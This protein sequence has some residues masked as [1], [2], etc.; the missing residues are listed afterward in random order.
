M[1]RRVGVCPCVSEGGWCHSG[2]GNNSNINDVKESLLVSL[3]CTCSRIKEAN[4]QY[5]TWGH[6]CIH[7]LSA[8]TQ[9]AHCP[10]DPACGKDT[11]CSDNSRKPTQVVMS[12]RCM[13]DTRKGQEAHAE[14]SVFSS[15]CLDPQGMPCIAVSSGR[16]SLGL[17]FLLPTRR[18]HK[19]SQSTDTLLGEFPPGKARLWQ[20]RGDSRTDLGAG[21]L[22]TEE[23]AK[24]LWH[25]YT[26]VAMQVYFRG[27]QTRRKSR[28]R[29]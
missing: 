20:L 26:S 5:P 4:H 24:C 21:S 10:Q 8:T 19:I 18:H 15:V 22:H 16:V 25:P 7:H 28:K 2:K 29:R 12:F 3:P 17:N 13:A 14:A 6:T 1:L 11:V 9:L 23:G 27:V